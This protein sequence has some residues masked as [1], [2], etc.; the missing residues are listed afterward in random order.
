[1]KEISI[2]INILAIVISLCAIYIV[3]KKRKNK[4]GTMWKKEN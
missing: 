1:M 2:A 4:E 3:I